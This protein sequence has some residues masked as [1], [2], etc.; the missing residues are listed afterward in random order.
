VENNA[1]I[2]LQNNRLRLLRI[3]IAVAK[4]LPVTIFEF[5]NFKSNLYEMYRENFRT[6]YKHLTNF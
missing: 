3:K 6:L 1:Y 2:R 5:N 4:H